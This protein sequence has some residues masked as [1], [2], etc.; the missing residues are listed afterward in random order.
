MASLFENFSIPPCIW[1]EGGDKR[2]ALAAL[3]SGFLVD[4]S[5]IICL[6]H[7]YNCHRF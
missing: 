1:F 7:F 3:L 2:N 6:V 5:L 4:D